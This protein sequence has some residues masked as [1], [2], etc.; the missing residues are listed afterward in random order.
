MT[1]RRAGRRLRRG[2]EPH[3]GVDQPGPLGGRGRGG[4]AHEPGAEAVAYRVTT[5]G[6]VVV[7]SDD[8]R[9]CQEVEDLSLGADLLSTRPA[10]PPPCATSSPGRPS[11]RSSATTPTRCRSAP[12]PNGPASVTLVLTHLIPAPT[13]ADQNQAFADDVRAGGFTGTVTVGR[14]LMTFALGPS[15]DPPA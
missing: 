11:R 5:P 8:T 6:G 2:V 3:R 14:D 1:T 15:G 13:S 4:R 7:I 9:V 10:G 12:R